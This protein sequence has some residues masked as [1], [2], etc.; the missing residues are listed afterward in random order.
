MGGEVGEENCQQDGGPDM[1]NIIIFRLDLKYMVVI[2]III[3]LIING[4]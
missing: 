4:N 2:I 3:R 1:L